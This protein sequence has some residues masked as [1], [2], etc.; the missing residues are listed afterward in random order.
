MAFGTINDNL[1]YII[2]IA[3][4]IALFVGVIIVAI[5]K[6]VKSHRRAKTAQEQ[7]KIEEAVESG[8]Q[9]RIMEIRNECLVLTRDVTFKVGVDGEIAMGSYVL[10]S[11]VSGEK[12]FNV[13]LNG[14]VNV[15]SDGDIITLGAGD[16]ICVVS[17]T[18]LL[19]P[20]VPDAVD[21]E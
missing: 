4:G 15:Y 9:Q 1:L 20:Y 2:L 5:V 17:G 3:L 6:V 11:S 12:Q 16:T 8:V 21:G 14:F 7:Q 19:K 18:A 10:K 13:R